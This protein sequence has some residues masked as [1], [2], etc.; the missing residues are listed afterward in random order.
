MGIVIHRESWELSTVT[1]PAERRPYPTDLT[2]EQWAAIAPWVQRPAGPGAPTTVSLREIVNALRYL[3]RAGCAWRL[4]PHEFPNHNTVRYYFDKW[5]WDGTFARIDAALATLDR[6]EAGRE[7][8]PSLL[9]VDS[10]TVKTSAAGGER[11]FDG[12]KK[13]QRPEATALRG[14]AG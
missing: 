8:Q 4:L 10:Q 7:P 9:I 13:Y 3:N 5:T 12:G 11:G 1:E 6:I 14:H 2:D